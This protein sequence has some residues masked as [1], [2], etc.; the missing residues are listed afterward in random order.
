MEKNEKFAFIMGLSVGVATISLIG[1]IV[2]GF[3][4]FKNNI[5][6]VNIIAA[7]TEKQVVEQNKNLDDGL[8]SI[9]TLDLPEEK[10]DGVWTRGTINASVTIVE[11]SDYQCPFCTRYHDT[12][13]QIMVGYTNLVK[14]EYKHL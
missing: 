13:K 1:I 5:N 8:I 9:K 6:S 11:Y 10:V 7:K 12:M 4:F 3:L 2:F 14:C